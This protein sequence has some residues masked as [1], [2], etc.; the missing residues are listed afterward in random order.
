M[1]QDSSKTAKDILD[2]YFLE[3]RARLLEIAAF[4]DRID[5]SENSDGAQSD[6]RYKA[7]M[8]ALKLLTGAEGWRTKNILLNFSDLSTEPIESATGLKGASGAWDKVA[9]EE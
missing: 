1:A 5:R 7:F 8:K 9:Y 3:N 4:L 2:I 6:F